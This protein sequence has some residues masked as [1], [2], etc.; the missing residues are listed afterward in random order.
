MYEVL[1]MI[2]FKGSLMVATPHG[3][4]CLVGTSFRLLPLERPGGSGVVPHG[5][6][7]PTGANDATS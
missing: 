6:V 4:Y 2:V 7:Q 1:S 5:G 3:V